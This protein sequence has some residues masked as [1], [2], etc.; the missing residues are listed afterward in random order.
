MKA[1]TRFHTIVNLAVVIFSTVLFE[2]CTAPSDEGAAEA[3]EA[4]AE[5]TTELVTGA[6]EEGAAEGGPSCDRAASWFFEEGGAGVS[7]AD[8]SGLAAA[9]PEDPRH[10]NA[11]TLDTL[12]RIAEAGPAAAALSDRL[13]AYVESPASDRI[14]A[15]AVRA[16]AAADPERFVLILSL[17]HISE[18]TR[19]Y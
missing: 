18:P 7:E 1:S 15:A 3:P 6:A 10:A 4:T 19:P 8:L 2:A 9:L 16:L 17:I 14:G 12:D 13:V 11:S 5:P